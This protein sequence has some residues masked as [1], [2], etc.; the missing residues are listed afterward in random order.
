ME[1][2]TVQ[3]SQPSEGTQ[4]RQALDPSQV[5]DSTD[6]IHQQLNRP[7]FPI[8]IFLRFL[9]FYSLAPMAATLSLLRIGPLSPRLTRP[10]LTVNLTP[11]PNRSAR[12]RPRV[13]PVSASY[14]VPSTDRL[15]SVLS[16]TLPCLNALPYGRLLISRYPILASL[17]A[18]LFP[19]LSAYQSVPQAGFVAFFALYLALARNPNMSRYVRFNA[20]QAVMLDVMLTLPVLLQRILGTPSGRAG[21]RVLEFGYG[22]IFVLGVGSFFYSVLCCVVGRTPYLPVVSSAA[23]GQL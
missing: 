7:K 17:T 18:P 23:N 8:P 14:T 4:L 11:Y 5:D 16:Y 9:G 2:G 22:A 6:Q 20:M 19:L 1:M 13:P 21:L 15:L 3:I 10:S 12:I